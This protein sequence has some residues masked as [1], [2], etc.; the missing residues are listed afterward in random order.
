MVVVHADGQPLGADA[1]GGQRCRHPV[2]LGHS[3]ARAAGECAG[4]R[5]ALGDRR[6]GADPAAGHL[7][8]DGGRDGPAP[9]PVLGIVEHDGQDH[10]GRLGGE[11]AYERGAVALG[12]PAVDD[13]LGRPRLACHAEPGHLCALGRPVLAHNALEV[14][15]QPLGRRFPERTAD[16]VGPDAPQHVAGRMTATLLD[17]VRPNQQPTVGERSIGDRQLERRHLDGVAPAHRGQCRPAPLVRSAER[18]GHLAR[19]VHERRLAEAEVAGGLVERAAPHPLG[20]LGHHDVGRLGDPLAE[21]DRPVAAR[22]LDRP[23]V[24]DA[25]ARA[26]V[27]GVLRVDGPALQ[28]GDGRD[29]LER[30]ARLD[31][32]HDGVVAPRGVRVGARPVRVER[33]DV[34]HR[35]DGPVVG[36]EGDGRA[37]GRARFSNA[38]SQLFF[39]NGL[40]DQVE[41]QHHVV[42]VARLHVRPPDDGAEPASAVALSHLAAGRAAQGFVQRHLQPGDATQVARDV[43]EHVGGARAVV[44]ATAVRARHD[45]PWHICGVQLLLGGLVEV[46]DQHHVLAARTVGHALAE[47]LGRAARRVR[48]HSVELV[49]CG[50]EATHG[51]VGGDLVARR[52]DHERPPGPV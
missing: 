32:V 42:S 39:Q 33:R 17:H 40:A 19:Q 31:P 14:G 3:G 41:R 24:E 45:E 11:H 7:A 34:R 1:V 18:A 10:L 12:V 43:A 37:P 15:H 26:R 25:P 16:R 23:P 2:H 28:P 52:V 21:R 38:P 9:V 29:E 46:A 6:E 5:H 4:R 48:Q 22:V 35:Q 49:G 30:R 50:V 51:R 20:S 8:E 44:V 47:V 13:P 36:V 27:E